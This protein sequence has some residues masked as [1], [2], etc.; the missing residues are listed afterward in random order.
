M[1]ELVLSLV[2]AAFLLIACDATSPPARLNN[3]ALFVLFNFFLAHSPSGVGARSGSGDATFPK[4]QHFG[5]GKCCTAATLHRVHRTMSRFFAAFQPLSSLPAMLQHAS[6]VNVDRTRRAALAAMLALPATALARPRKKR[7][8]VAPVRPLRAGQAF[9]LPELSPKGPAVA[10]VNL[11]TQHV[12]IYR[13]AIAIAYSSISSGRPGHATPTG[14]FTV[15]EKRRHHRSNIYNNAPMPWMVRLTWDGVAFHGG[16]LP[17]YPASH[18]CIRL[19]MHFAPRLFSA[20]SY[21]DAVLVVRQGVE[22]GVGPL[23]ALAPI[24]PY[25]RPTVSAEMMNA[26]EWWAADAFEPLVP[27]APPAPVAAPASSASAASIAAVEDGGEEAAPP[28]PPPP[29]PPLALLACLPQQ[30]LFVLRAGRVIGSS[31]LHSSA[32][33]AAHSALKGKKVLTWSGEQ[34]RTM[35]GRGDVDAAVWRWML[36]EGSFSERLRP[37]L[38]AGNTLVLSDLPAVD[39]GLAVAW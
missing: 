14:L 21:G 39:K 27:P 33:L 17:G 4:K 26:N 7:A 24:D 5:A 36:P 25:G 10:M 1:V 23:T 37:L 30:R 6:H 16:A 34:W 3:M 20:L 31:A 15:L 22:A 32:S 9:W 8:A 2:S 28:A 18:G 29:P 35:N 12:Q 38:E 13:N 19:P 11:H